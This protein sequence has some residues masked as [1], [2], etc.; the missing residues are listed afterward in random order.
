MEDTLQP[1]IDRAMA[2]QPAFLEFYLRDQSRL[3]GTRANLEL[4]QDLSHHLALL[5]SDF[6]GEM[7]ALLDHLLCDERHV[8]SNTPGEFVVLCGVLGLGACAAAVPA[9]REDA[10]DQLAESACNSAWRVR[11]GTAT[12][13]QKLLAVAPDETLLKL[14]DWL[15]E[16]DCL[17]MRACLAAVAEPALLT[18]ERVI[19]SALIMQRI[20]LEYLHSLPREE[21]KV[22]AT[23][24]MRQA[25]G[26]TL[27]VVTAASP[28][29]GFALMCEIATWNDVDI[30]WVLRE[31]LKKRRLAKFRTY[32]E[33]VIALMA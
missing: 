21:R 6:P 2:G 17:Q 25:L 32:T 10:F 29:D 23:R 24:V 26:Y 13:L 31:N 12:A 28:D 5:A 33:K 4:A 15:D 19:S 27:S 9:W 16:G 11:E 20:A 1:L 14:L 3:P 8:V 30:N 18:S 22:P 7:R